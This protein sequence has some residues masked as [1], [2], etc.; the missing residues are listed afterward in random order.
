[1]SDSE[2]DAGLKKTQVR[3][4]PAPILKTIKDKMRSQG[5]TSLS[6][7]SALKWAATQYAIQLQEKELAAA[8]GG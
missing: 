7:A 5:I 1:M 3:D 6:D 2:P 4:V 8:N